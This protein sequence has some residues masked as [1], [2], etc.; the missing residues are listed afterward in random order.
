MDVI[1]NVQTTVKTQCSIHRRDDM[2]NAPSRCQVQSGIEMPKS[3]GYL[4]YPKDRRDKLDKRKQNQLH[5]LNW[6][7]TIGASDGYR[8]YRRPCIGATFGARRDQD[9]KVLRHRFNRRVTQRH[10]YNQCNIVQRRCQVRSSQAFST[11]LTDVPSEQLRCNVSKKW[12]RT[13][14][15]WRSSVTGLTDAHALV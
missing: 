1:Q 7:C 5:R 6:R 9:K 15:K 10:R 11:N 3:H 13:T 2:S 8:I 14:A 12:S 4:K